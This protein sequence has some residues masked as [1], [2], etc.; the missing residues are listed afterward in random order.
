MIDR[1]DAALGWASAHP[2]GGRVI[3]VAGDAADEE[4][5]GQ[6]ADLAQDAGSLAGW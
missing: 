4:V 3:P 1:D 2:A 5:T 6:A